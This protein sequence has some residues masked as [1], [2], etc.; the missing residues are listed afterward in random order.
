MAARPERGSAD[1]D[2]IGAMLDGLDAD[3]G[4]ACRGEKFELM[5]LHALERI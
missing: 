4:I 2:G 3:V 5:G 1:V